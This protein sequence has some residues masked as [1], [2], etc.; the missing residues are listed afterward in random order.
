MK[1]KNVYFIKGKNIKELKCFIWQHRSSQNRFNL[2][3]KET[4]EGYTVISD[5]VYIEDGIVYYWCSSEVVS[6]EEEVVTPEY[7]DADEYSKVEILIHG[8]AANTFHQYCK[9]DR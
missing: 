7:I 1:A 8:E 3:E 2:V 6:I 9:R 5:L 4:A